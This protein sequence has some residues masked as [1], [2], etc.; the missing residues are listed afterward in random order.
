MKYL[1]IITT[2]FAVLLSSC[3][4]KKQEKGQQSLL[5][6]SKQELAAALEE[7]DQLLCIVKE[8]SVSMDQIKNF[9]NIMAISGTQSLEK[10]DQRARLLSDMAVVKESLKHRRERLVELESKLQES[11]LY[12]DDM[13]GTIKALRNQIDRQTEEIENLRCQLFS[14][15]EHINTLNNEVDSLNTTV[16]IVNDNLDAAQAASARLENELNTCYF[17]VASKSQLKEH[18]IIETGFL[19]K[20]KLLEGDFDKEFFSI[21]DKRDLSTLNLQ[22]NKVKI[23]TNHPG[24][25]YEIGNVD[26]N[27]VLTI[28]NPEKFWSLTNYL[29]IQ[30]E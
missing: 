16:A 25:S 19:R 4:N 18:H 21:G 30:I 23:Y 1:L 8:I 29:V 3:G 20:S 24:D 2:V 12:T 28:T 6:A 22:S 17:V 5:E 9:E 14:A 26:K 10:P 7:R 27:K 15:N 11:A 13:K